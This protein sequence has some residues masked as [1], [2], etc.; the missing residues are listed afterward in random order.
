MKVFVSFDGDHI[1]RMVGR[2]SLADK[3]E[4]VAKI[5]QAI[6][7]GN[8]IWR[9]WALS[10][11][12][13][14][15]SVG[16]DEG[17]LEV[18]A[19]HLTELPKI[20]DQ[21][22][23][24]VGSTVSV[25]VGTKLSEADKSLMA[26]K[27]Q[28]GDRIQLYTETVNELLEELEDKPESQKLFD[29]YLDPDTALQ[30]AEPHDFLAW[31]RG[32]N[33]GHNFRQEYKPP[34]YDHGKA[35]A[36][37]KRGDH[38]HCTKAACDLSTNGRP[39]DL[40]KIKKAQPGMNQGANAGFSGA[41]RSTPAAPQGEASEHSEAEVARGVYGQEPPQLGQ[42]APQNYEELFHQIA[43]QTPEDQPQKPSGLQDQVRAQIVQV[44]QDV[45]SKADKL[46]QIKA[47]NPD[48]YN[49]VKGLVQAMIAM[50]Q[51]ADGG[52][53]PVQK[54]EG[55]VG[56]CKWKLGERRCQRQVTGD[57]CHDHKD[58]W[59]NKIKQKAT[60]VK[61][62]I[63]KARAPHEFGQVASDQLQELGQLQPDEPAY[64][65]SD[66]G[67]TSRPVPSQRVTRD[68]NGVVDIRNGPHPK[69]F[70]ILFDHPAYP[71]QPEHEQRYIVN[72]GTFAQAAHAARTHFMSRFPHL[73][74]AQ[75]QTGLTNDLG[76]PTPS[77]AAFA[78]MPK[79]WP[80]HQ[81]IFGD[82]PGQI[83]A[84]GHEGPPRDPMVG[85]GNSEPWW[86]RQ[87]DGS[88]TR[89]DGRAYWDLREPN[90]DDFPINKAL[91][92]TSRE[93]NIQAA[94]EHLVMQDA[95]R[96]QFPAETVIPQNGLAPAP[97]GHYHSEFP[98]KIAAAKPGAP[99]SPKWGP[100]A[101]DA[102]YTRQL[103]QENT[104]P[105]AID[106][107]GRVATADN[108]NRNVNTY[109]ILGARDSNSPLDSPNFGY[110]IQNQFPI[111]DFMHQKGGASFTWD[112]AYPGEHPE[113]G[114]W[115]IREYR[116][117]HN[118]RVWAPL[119][120]G[121]AVT[122]HGP[123]PWY[124][125]LTPEAEEE[126]KQALAAHLKRYL[127]ANPNVYKSELQKAD[128]MPGGKGDN[129]PDS[130]FDPEQLSTGVKR[131]MEEHGLDEARAKE[132]AKD[133]LTENPQYYSMEK[134]AL[135][136]SKT[137]RHNVVL[138][139]GSQIDAGPSADHEAGK[140]KVRNPEDGKTKWRSVRAGVVMAPDG[141]PT[142]SRNPGG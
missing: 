18:E 106:R 33:Q 109:D 76:V 85:N 114:K 111:P 77:R 64:R 40:E 47:S 131:E 136:P 35:Y 141:S 30:K 34:N 92:P 99:V 41:S 27:L 128:L 118:P 100:Q 81:A 82:G 51:A 32:Q 20:R 22:Q 53:E 103:V 66:D 38:S 25:G 43:S 69:T 36:M 1:G 98:A 68:R 55:K 10:H 112:E 125:G 138:P 26:A 133:H 29:E 14:V 4:E 83:F 24:V 97:K 62:E 2:A 57:Y 28:G 94:N 134:A 86:T 122:Y 65:L 16:G 74:P 21:Y 23:A 116:G 59:A 8:E 120:N 39:A 80:E 107:R 73:N 44:L 139:V 61:D 12:G 45:R 11:G 127:L 95:V 105:S 140:I 79:D 130:D 19:D 102:N 90:T 37:H 101:T 129:K 46:E 50:A 137:G 89:P 91:P 108:Q 9:S 124:D 88:V 117:G 31:S 56:Q 121:E 67:D 126:R 87:P 104:D 13:R 93:A 60:Q 48:L 78:K 135:Q 42:G 58:H 49:S 63:R 15:I 84:M 110:E 5:A 115:V 96:E 75:I 3:P 132:I 71:D 70:T 6:D 123:Q 54:A 7:R 17:R 142:S 119:A 72:A 52:E 113:K